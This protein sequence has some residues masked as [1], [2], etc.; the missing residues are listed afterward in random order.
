MDNIQLARSYI[1]ENHPG[2]PVPADSYL[3]LSTARSGSTMLTTYL[4]K[5]GFGF[6]IEAFNPNKNS[7]ER[8][9]WGIDY[10][11][12]YAYIKKAIEFQTVGTVMGMKF[13]PN[14]FFVFLENARKLLAPT[15]L[16]Y[17]D[18]E[19]VEIFFP[20]AK[21]IHLERKNKLK[22]AISFS[23]ALQ[24][25]IWR[26]VEGEDETYKEYI[27]PAVYDRDHIERCFDLSLANDQ[28]WRHYLRSNELSYLH[29]YYEELTANYR[30]EMAQIH[31]YLGIE[32][33]NIVVPSLRKQAT[34]LSEEW[35]T[36]FIAETDWFS[37]TR[38]NSLL[39]QD[40]QENLFIERCH[41]VFNKR[42]QQ[43]YIAMPSIRYKGLR[44]IIF[45][46]L[47]KFTSL[48]KCS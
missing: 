46:V 30:E 2:F 42:E 33:Q 19:L 7:R 17:E 36:R 15:D 37:T 32:D 5:I 1:Q 27:T 38:F 31:Q 10:S 18:A 12:P 21:Y 4:G 25:G 6:P 41:I 28:Y 29:I 47:R 40:D 45:R 22:Q 26:E 13:M 39:E 44:S 35:E 3:V 14:Q 9:N 24:D 11:D 8:Y 16:N 48:L 20:S 34:R 43:R 23:K